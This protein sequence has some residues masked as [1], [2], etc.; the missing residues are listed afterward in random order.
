MTTIDL[1]TST[2]RIEGPGGPVT[3]PEVSYRRIRAEAFENLA[4]VP[5]RVEPSAE[6]PT[7]R[8]LDPGG[9]LR[10]LA[11]TPTYLGVVPRHDFY[12]DPIPIG[13]EALLGHARRRLHGLSV[14]DLGPAEAD[15]PPA[16][17]GPS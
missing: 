15:L 13:A 11:D 1:W 17:G 10:I 4:G 9:S 5:H 16:P 14:E 7:H 8:V 3:V 2:R 6:A 12:P